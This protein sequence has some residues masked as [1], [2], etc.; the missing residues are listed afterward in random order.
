MSGKNHKM[1]DGKLLQMDK[2]Y[3]GQCSKTH[4]SGYSAY[5]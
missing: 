3:K 2:Q 4:C 5:R 1:I